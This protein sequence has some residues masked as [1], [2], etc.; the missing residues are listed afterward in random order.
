MRRR[1]NAPLP[2]FF[3]T[4]LLV[5]L[6]AGAF[7]QAGPAPQ[8]APA[9][10]Q[11]APKPANWEKNHLSWITDQI[12]EAV[13]KGQHSTSFQMEANDDRE[14]CGE[15]WFWK[16]TPYKAEMKRV[17][18]HFEDLG[19]KLEFYVKNRE[20]VD[21]SDLNPRDNWITYETRLR[22]SW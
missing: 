11:P 7:A 14:R 17:M 20:N 8:P 5:L 1:N 2:L 22:I 12:T 18:K 4:T 16:V 15:E 6:A 13:N 21:L 19:Y 9:D 3:L 10:S